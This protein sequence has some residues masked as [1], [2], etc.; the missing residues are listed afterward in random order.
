MYLIFPVLLRDEVLCSRR[1]HALCRPLRN[2]RGRDGRPQ[3]GLRCAIRRLLLVH[4]GALLV[5]AA[6][7]VDGVLLVVVAEEVFGIV[8]LL[9]IC[10]IDRMIGRRYMTT[11][12]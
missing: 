12:C 4:V 2:L 8:Q 9:N 11:K 10:S 1:F 6:F 5:V 7:V 3:Y